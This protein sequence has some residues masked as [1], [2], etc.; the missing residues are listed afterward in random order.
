MVWFCLPLAIGAAAFS[1]DE[2]GGVSVRELQRRAESALKAKRFL[3]AAEALEAL[4]RERPRDAFVR[5]NLACARSMGGDL[6]GAEQALEDAVAAGFIEFFHMERDPHLEPARGTRTFRLLIKGWPELLNA[7]GESD[8]AALRDRFVAGAAPTG[9]R[10][11]SDPELRLH[12]A[13]SFDGETFEDARA[14]IARVTVWA[15]RELFPK[16]PEEEAAARPDPW[17]SIVLP[18]PQDFFRLVFSGGIGGYYDKDRRRLVTQDIGPSLRHEFLHVLHWR[19]AERLG[20]KHPLWIMEG[21]ASLLEDVETPGEASTGGFVI[22]PS[23]RTNIAGRLARGAG[24]MPLARFISLS[25]EK[26]MAERPRA[27]YGQARALCMYL[28]EKGKLGAWFAEYTRRYGEDPTGKLALEAVFDL[29]LKKVEAGFRAWAAALPEVAEQAKPGKFGLGVSVS[30]GRGDGVEIDRVVTGS[31]LSGGIKNPLRFKDV[32][33][34]IEGQQIRT[35]DDYVR[36]IGEL[37]EGVEG[38]PAEPKGVA[39]GMRVPFDDPPVLLGPKV[40]VKVRRAKQ[41]MEFEV[42]MV[43]VPENLMDF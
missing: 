3:E 20:Q 32:I 30:G 26:F 14:Q 33:Y 25:D 35:L 27:G 4:A 24:L 15:E 18:T 34:E 38:K 8:L 43:E 11:E 13:S 23:W 9:Y 41:E 21:L 29:P 16:V 5:Y 1:Q 39:P 40:K 7:R 6:A 22:R 10:F 31:R 42:T 28:H 36:V 37:Q 17:V 12:Y 2:A 19:Y